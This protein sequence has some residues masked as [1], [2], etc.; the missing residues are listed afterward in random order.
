MRLPWRGPQR[1]ASDEATRSLRVLLIDDDEDEY[2]LVRD[3]FREFEDTD[4]ELEWAASYGAG[5]EAVKRAEHDVYLVDYRLGAMNGVD[6]VREARAAGIRAPLIMLTGQREREV[7]MAAMEAGAVD[8]LVKGRTEPVLLERT[9]R[10]AIAQAESTIALERSLAQVE[11]LERV[12]RLLAEHGPTPEALDA[13][14]DVL[15]SQ[16]DQA[17]AAVY[18]MERGRL[19]LAAQ[20]GYVAAVPQLDPASGRLA[21]LLTGG[22]AALVPTIATDPDSEA[23]HGM[24]LAV[25]LMNR[26]AC[27]G[28]LLVASPDGEPLSG[29]DF[30]VVVTLAD[31]VAVAMA[32]ADEHD[33]LSARV[34]RTDRLVAFARTVGATLDAERL[35]EEIVEA[36]ATVVPA[37]LVIL[38]TPDPA[39]A[40][41]VRAARGASSPVGASL[42]AHP[43][44]GEGTDLLAVIDRQDIRAEHGALQELSGGALARADLLL[45]RD[46]QTVGRLVFARRDPRR[47]FDPGEQEAIRIMGGLIV[48]ALANVASHA[49]VTERSVRDPLTGLP[50]RRFFQL[51]V[52]Q[53][54]AQRARQEPDLRGPMAAIMYDLDHFGA[55]NKQHGHAVGDTVLRAFAA[56]LGARTRQGDIV[57]RYGGEEFAVVMVDATRDDAMRVAEE[58]LA[59]FAATAVTLDDGT[60]LRATV[61]AG[62]AALGADENDVDGLLRTADVALSVAK[63]AGRN[64]AMAA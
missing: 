20:R 44:R 54:T 26:S 30:H 35:H 49:E 56:V 40:E 47:P 52:T 14:L 29:S 23:R 15:V 3:A 63:R 41:I 27:T 22:G 46:E 16:L 25:P 51:S 43:A 37:D 8:F 11:G 48:L 33:E 58:I 32:L 42:E 36:A 18:L 9:I 6:L 21:K 38:A 13:V 45:E 12:G 59:A 4:Y 53:L 1:R 55:I 10:Y 34:S 28:L 60:E 5:I 50:N 64:V 17:A 62:C 31:R 19:E 57:A 2:T 61:S 24:E 7:D 39:G